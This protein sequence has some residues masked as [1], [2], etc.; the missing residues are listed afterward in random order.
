MAHAQLLFLPG[1]GRGRGCLWGLL[2]P[3]V[4]RRHGETEQRS[5]TEA[6]A[7]L[8]GRPVC[9]PLGLY[10]SRDLPGSVI[11]ELGRSPRAGV[12]GSESLL[13]FRGG[14]NK[15]GL[16]VLHVFRACLAGLSSS[17]FFEFLLAIWVVFNQS[18]NPLY[19]VL[20][21]IK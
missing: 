5:Q 8:Q 6:A 3:L 18:H 13:V 19:S 2:V 9:H 4:R 12:G 17:S 15:P 14:E 11:E 10:S 1:S 16:R 21:S 20:T 7:A